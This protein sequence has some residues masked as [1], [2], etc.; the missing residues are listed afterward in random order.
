MNWE[1]DPAQHYIIGEITYYFNSRVNDLSEMVFD[2]SDALQVNS[3]TRNG[4]PLSFIHS[5][6]QLLTID[7]EKSLQ[8]NDQD[9]LTV[10]YQ[11]AP[12]SNGFGS[13]YTRDTCGTTYRMDFVRTLWCSG[14]VAGKAGPG[15]QD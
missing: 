5:T 11:G 4:I 7:L 6:D 10:F 12:P 9:T 14:L 15:G 13:F 3:V 1:I 2:L 8:T